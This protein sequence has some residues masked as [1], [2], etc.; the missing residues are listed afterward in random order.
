MRSDAT[1][2]HIGRQR[3]Q[4]RIR[5]GQHSQAVDWKFGSG[6]TASRGLYDFPFLFRD[7][8]R[9]SPQIHPLSL[10]APQR[11]FAKNRKFLKM[12]EVMEPRMHHVP[13]TMARDAFS[14]QH[15]PRC[16]RRR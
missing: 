15:D 9:L 1:D 16:R 6:F 8:L 12:Q 7:N 10:G 14:R 13:L 5:F 2:K 4:I 3:P 11:V